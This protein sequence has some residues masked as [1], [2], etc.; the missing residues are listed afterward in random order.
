MVRKGDRE[1]A[2]ELERRLLSFHDSN[3][4]LPGIFELDRRNVLIE[5][6][7]ESIR[8][9]R[10]VSRMLQRDVS[11]SR[12]NPTSELFDP[13]KAALYFKRNGNIDEAYWMV[14]LFVHFGKNSKAGWRYA[15]EVYG[16][17]G[18]GGRWD[19]AAVSSDPS[20]FRLWLDSRQAQLKRLGVP[21]GF[22]NHRKY[23]SLDAHSQYGTGAAFESYVEWVGPPRTHQEMMSQ[24]YR[25]AGTS[26]RKAFREL[27]DT[28][29]I[30]SSFGRTARFDYLAMV[31]RLELASILPDSPY[32]QGSTGP[33]KGARL[34]FGNH[35]S[36]KQLNDWSIQ[37]G[38]HLEV[39][40][41]EIEDSICNWQKSP[42]SFI[43]FRT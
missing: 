28:M 31:G 39:G 1:L 36:P 17:L 41:Q 40:M 21:R 25:K 16:R 6:M 24:V 8:R 19:W 3:R 37:L 10:Y 20:A 11:E 42:T 26:P 29:R 15:R 5:Q 33:L 30:I 35:G 14:F 23:Q 13:F 9:V 2:A 34:L 43:P 32:L 4:S 18:E 27:Y 7:V 22:G 12:S 38:R